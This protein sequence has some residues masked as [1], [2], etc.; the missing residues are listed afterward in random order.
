MRL[1]GNTMIKMAENLKKANPDTLEDYD[2]SF[3][4]SYASE[5][6]VYGNMFKIYSVTSPMR[7]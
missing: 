4:D 5:F 6:T 1:T 3:A 2:S 7:L